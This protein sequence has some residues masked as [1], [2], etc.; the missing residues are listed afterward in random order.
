M[1]FTYSTLVIKKERLIIE[2]I[3]GIKDSLQCIEKGNG[4][5][6]FKISHSKRDDFE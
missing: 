1:C 3:F 4:K 6:R 5:F 2:I